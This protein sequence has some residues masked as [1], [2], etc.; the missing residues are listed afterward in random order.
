MGWAGGAGGGGA[1]AARRTHT[2]TCRVGEVPIGWCARGLG[3]T[4]V[5]A[6]LELRCASRMSCG[7]FFIYIFWDV[8]V[9]CIHTLLSCDMICHIHT[10]TFFVTWLYYSTCIVTHNRPT[11]AWFRTLPPQCGVRATCFSRSTPPCIGDAPLGAAL[12]PVVASRR[13][14]THEQDTCARC[15]GPCGPHPTRFAS[16]ILRSG[17]AHTA[18]VPEGA[19]SSA[20]GTRDVGLL[21]VCWS[22][23]IWSLRSPGSYPGFVAWVRV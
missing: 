1:G 15:L 21:R 19:W 14:T 17:Y 2:H 16:S 23:A 11:V 13:S 3:N 12:R 20:R 7:I 22:P 18:S 8:F 9:T 10:L 4:C 5:G 6:R